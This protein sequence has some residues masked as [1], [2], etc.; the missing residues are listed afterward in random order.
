MKKPILASYV[1]YLESITVRK[2]SDSHLRLLAAMFSKSPSSRM[3]KYSC[4]SKKPL[5]PRQRYRGGTIC[6][7]P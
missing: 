5:A 1:L 4:D 2:G 3:Q 7:C 6:M